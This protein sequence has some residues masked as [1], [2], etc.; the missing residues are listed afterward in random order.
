[1]R[2]NTIGFNATQLA[3]KHFTRS[4]SKSNSPAALLSKFTNVDVSFESKNENKDTLLL[5]ILELYRYVI[6]DLARKPHIDI[7]KYPP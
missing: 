1:M 2:S 4:T 3:S 6:E 5:Y 7:K